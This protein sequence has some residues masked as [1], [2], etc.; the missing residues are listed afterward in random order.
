MRACWSLVLGLSTLLLLVACGGADAT[1]MPTPT[2]TPT[3]TATPTPTPT[4]T[5]S[6]TATPTPT[7][8]AA[9]PTPTHT[10]TPTPIDTALPMGT[11]QQVTDEEC[12]GSF[13][14]QC[15]RAVVTCPGIDDAAVNLRVTGAGTKG[16]ILLT[17]G[18]RG[19]RW[20][21]VGEEANS[22]NA[23]M[24]T[25]LADGYKLVEVAWMQPGVWEGPGGTISLAC[26]SATVFDWVHENIHQGGLLAAQGN[27]G[28]SAQI[29]FSLAYY[30]LDEILDLANLSGGPPP[31]PISTE[32]KINFQEQEQC[33]VGAERWDESKEPMLSGNPRF[34]YPNTIVRFFLGENEPT[35]Y[36]VETANAYHAAITSDKSLQVV[37]NTGHGVPFTEEGAEA[38]IA[39]I[40][41]A[42][43]SD[44][45]VTPTSTPAPTPTPTPTPTLALLGHWEGAHQRPIGDV[46]IIVDFW[47]DAEGLHGYMTVPDQA[48]SLTLA[49][50][51]FDPPGIHF[52]DGGSGIFFDGELQGDTISGEA[53]RAGRSAPFSLKRVQAAQEIVALEPGLNRVNFNHD[54]LVRRF[55]VQ[56]PDSFQRDVAYPVVFSFHGGGGIGEQSLEPLA[57]LANSEG[58]V[59]VL[60]DAFGPWWNNLGCVDPRCEAV[61]AQSRAEGVIITTADD[62]GYV[63]AVLDWLALQVTVDEA[64]VY[65]TGFSS[66]AGMVKRLALE[67]ERFAA[68]API[69]G[70]HFM[71]GET[72]AP[73]VPPLSVFKF[74][75]ELDGGYNGAIEL[76]VVFLSARESIARWTVHNGCNATPEV[77]TSQ[78]GIT[79]Y[80]HADCDSSREVL[81]YAVHEGGHWPAVSPDGRP[82]LPVGSATTRDRTSAALY[83]LMWDFFER[84]PQSR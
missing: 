47:T 5:L 4:P 57:R 49:Q 64:R 66:G 6:P 84:N 25:L 30:G 28:G 14:D 10:P 83:E 7:L 26:R 12:P 22:I 43:G 52:A 40:R 17:T 8:A 70:A 3:A 61:H 31:C 73:E 48:R 75:G 67:S 42:A 11:L 62:V 38:L 59:A 76:G 41:G 32:G 44:L 50:V 60:P 29:A 78:S 39:S 80:R 1:P 15:K 81:L 65:A 19:T 18:G 23:M 45:P 71:E 56:L 9:T 34:H 77:D 51:S 13:G 72:I 2:P 27:S 54:G 20:Y 58:F 33:L 63:R 37:P 55:L 79:I 24:D 36:I 53:G 46:E 16:T 74:F 82:L 35:E 69:G 68:I 21:R